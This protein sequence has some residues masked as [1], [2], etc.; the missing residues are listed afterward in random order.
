GFLFAAPAAGALLQALAGG[1]VRHVR[2]QGDAVIWA[3]IGWG[4]AITAFGVVGAHLWL[5]MFFL[6][7]AGAADVISAIYRSTILQ[8]TV[9]DELR[10]R[11]GGIFMLVVAGGPKL[12]DLEAGLVASAFTP[13][14]SVISG[15]I[16]CMVGAVIVA[17]RYPELRR[18]RAEQSTAE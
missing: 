7:V 12:G 4:A 9:P 3:V 11:L 13:T 15:G 6:A 17:I 8:M 5:A 1:W 18:Y 16:A 14:I 10:G 2:R